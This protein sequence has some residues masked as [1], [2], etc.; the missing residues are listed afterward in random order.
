LEG[1]GWLITKRRHGSFARRPAEAPPGDQQ[2][3]MEEAAAAF[4]IRIAQ[5]GADPA[6]ALRVAKDAL[7]SMSN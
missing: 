3:A 1:D 7:R 4:A 6:D 2:R 5:V